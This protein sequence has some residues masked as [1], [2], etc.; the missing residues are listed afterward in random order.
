MGERGMR[1]NHPGPWGSLGLRFGH[2]KSVMLRKRQNQGFDI[3][4]GLPLRL[5]DR[6]SVRT[7]ASGFRRLFYPLLPLENHGP[8]LVCGVEFG[9]NVL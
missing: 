7:Q 6:E 3:D 1:P 2:C 9:L 8:H 5:D 4:F